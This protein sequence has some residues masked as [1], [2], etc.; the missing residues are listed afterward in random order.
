MF[1]FI[2]KLKTVYEIPEPFEYENGLSKFSQGL[3]VW[4]TSRR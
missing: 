1:D 2:K 4:M 3:K